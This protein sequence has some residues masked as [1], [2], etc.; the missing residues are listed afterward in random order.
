LTLELT[1]KSVEIGFESFRATVIQALAG[2]T[3]FP[4]KL[5]TFAA[6]ITD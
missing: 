4:T 5:F 3:D 1:L 2:P 6:T